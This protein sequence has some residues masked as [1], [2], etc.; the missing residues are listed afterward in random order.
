VQLLNRHCEY[1]EKHHE[2][3]EQP[4]GRFPFGN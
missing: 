1:L 2:P 4:Y 3:P